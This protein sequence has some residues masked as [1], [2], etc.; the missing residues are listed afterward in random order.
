MQCWRETQWNSSRER[1]RKWDE[2]RQKNLGKN[3]VTEDLLAFY[4][5]SDYFIK[6]VVIVGQRPVCECARLFL[7]VLD[8]LLFSED[9]FYRNVNIIVLVLQSPTMWSFYSRQN[10]HV[11]VCVYMFFLFGFYFFSRVTGTKSGQISWQTWSKTILS[12]KAAAWMLYCLKK[13]A[14]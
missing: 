10:V 13:E 8:V 3:N 11:C 5:F 7:M 2:K 1:E 4:K 14:F 6:M 9:L 12:N